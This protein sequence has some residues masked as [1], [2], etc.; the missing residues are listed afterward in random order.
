VAKIVNPFTPGHLGDVCN[1]NNPTLTNLATQISNTAPGSPQS[2]QLWHQAMNIIVGNA[3]GIWIAYD[4]IL[5]GMT[6]RVVAPN[7]LTAYQS[8]ELSYWTI[9]LG[10]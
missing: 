9:H 10:G 6:T 1:Y 4:P 7:V 5:T 3:L 8:P 2:V